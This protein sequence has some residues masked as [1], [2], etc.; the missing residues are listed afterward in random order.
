MRHVM[1]KRGVASLEE[2]IAMAA[3]LGVKL[4]VCEMSMGLLGLE[5]EE[6]IDYPGLGFCGVATFIEQAANS[7]VSMFL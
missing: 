4:S 7:K 1:K 6:L 3:E 2:L 5:R